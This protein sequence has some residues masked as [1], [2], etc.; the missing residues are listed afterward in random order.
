MTTGIV[1]FFNMPNQPVVSRALPPLAGFD[2]NDLLKSD[3]DL[4]SEIQQGRKPV[5]V[6]HAALLFGMFL[7]H[8]TM[9]MMMASMSA[10]GGMAQAIE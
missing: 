3:D 2:E 9:K 8:F 4:M 1:R 10:S 5:K 6:G 7:Q